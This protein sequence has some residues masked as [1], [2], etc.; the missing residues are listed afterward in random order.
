MDQWTLCRVRRSLGD[1]HR[2]LRVDRLNSVGQLRSPDDQWRSLSLKEVHF[3]FKIWAFCP[4]PNLGT[5]PFPTSQ[6][7]KIQSHNTWDGP[8]SIAKIK[9][10]DGTECDLNLYHLVDLKVWF[11]YILAE[12]RKEYRKRGNT[13]DMERVFKYSGSQ[14]ANQS[15][16]EKCDVAETAPLNSRIFESDLK[17][18]RAVHGPVTWD[19]SLCTFESTTPRNAD[20]RYQCSICEQWNTVSTLLNEDCKMSEQYEMERIQNLATNQNQKLLADKLGLDG[21][22]PSAP[23]VTLTLNEIAQ[24]Q[25]VLMLGESGCGKSTVLRSLHSQHPDLCVFLDPVDL[26]W[27]HD[28]AVISEFDDDYSSDQRINLMSSIGLNT[29]RSWLKPFR[30]LSNGERYRASFSR[31]LSTGL[32]RQNQWI[33]ID[34]FTSVLDRANARC[35]ASSISKYIRRN[36]GNEIAKF[37]VASSKSDIIPYL[38]PDAVISLAPNRPHR[39]VVNPNNL[40]DPNSYVPDTKVVLDLPPFEQLKQNRVPIFDHLNFDEHSLRKKDSIS[41]EGRVR[42]LQCQIRTDEHTATAS[43][44]FDVVKSVKTQ[45]NGNG[46]RQN[47][48]PFDGVTVTDIPCLER[49]HIGTADF[50]IGLIYGPSGSG[51]TLAGERLFGRITTFQWDTNKSIC[52]HFPSLDDMEDKFAACSLSPRLGLSKYHQLSQGERDRVDIAIKLG[53][54]NVLIDEFTSNVDRKTAMKVASGLRVYVDRH[55]LKNVVLLSCHSDFVSMLHPDWLFDVENKKVIHYH[56]M[57]RSSTSPE[58]TTNDS[59]V[60]N[61]VSEDGGYIDN[62]R[63]WFRPKIRIFLKPSTYKVFEPKFAKYHYMSRTINTAAT[64]FTAWATFGFSENEQSRL[65]EQAECVGFISI[66]SY[67]FRAYQHDPDTLFHWREHRT[68]ILP[69][70]QGMGFG[71]RICDALALYLSHRKLDDAPNG[72]RLQSKTAHPRYGRSKDMSPLWLPLSTNHLTD[73]RS[74][75]SRRGKEEVEEK[76]FYSH[77]FKL[78]Y[79]WSESDRYYLDQSVIVNE[80]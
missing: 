53:S 68:V 30:I 77:V 12:K 46:K 24:Y 59:V 52:D 42:R 14:L 32:K 57:G 9:K 56:P 45:D 6:I 25:I 19:C 62:D 31:L 75:W 28:K 70:Y 79:Q 38:Q 50:S 64:C 58:F 74:L 7:I 33:L 80:K 22:G 67:P 76:M 18:Q 10:R 65:D 78:E 15:V 37:V 3:R 51:K 71:S 13:I 60:A 40:T 47:P 8:V 29:V 69:P 36:T 20:G 11:N 55:Q 1:E 23:D 41:I 54:N 49:H 35:I 44:V 48:I 39:I 2:T 34:E 73:K 17:L 63:M 27:H 61:D 21:S 43:S 66:L 26:E 72:Q 5:K 16:A 4:T